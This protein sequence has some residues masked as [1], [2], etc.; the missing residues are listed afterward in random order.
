VSDAHDDG[1][2]SERIPCSDERCTGIYHA[3]GR[4]GVCKKPVPLQEGET[5]TEA[6]TRLSGAP[7]EVS[8]APAPEETPAR[9]IKTS[10]DE[11][12]AIETHGEE[13]A[14]DDGDDDRVPCPDDACTGVIGASG[15]CG[16][17]GREGEAT[18]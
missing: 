1:I 18:A 7:V 10:T 3:D 11:P 4:C 5:P 14:R 12:E 16:V 13:E 6:L 9:P 15:R 8:D 2:L 17:C